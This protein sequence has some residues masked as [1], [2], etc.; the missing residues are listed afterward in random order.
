[1]GKTEGKG[2][3]VFIKDS[4]KQKLKVHWKIK[5]GEKL[6]NGQ[7][8]IANIDFLNFPAPVE[9]VDLIF[10]ALEK[11]A[12]KLEL[13][14]DDGACVDCV[15]YDILDF[16]DVGVVQISNPEMGGGKITTY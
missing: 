13:H 16:S 9:A 6:L 2:Y 10:A 1:M 12:I 15:I 7:S 11:S 8:W 5:H 3:L 14:T 4:K